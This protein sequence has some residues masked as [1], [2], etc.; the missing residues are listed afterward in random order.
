[1]IDF[2]TWADMFKSTAENAGKKAGEV[3]EVTKIKMQIAQ[4]RTELSRAY[5]K[6]GAMVYDMMKNDVQD[7]S[8]VDVCIDE[9]D[10]ILS[11]ITD[12]ESKA[13]ELKKVTVCA[14]CG[15]EMALD[16][17]FCSKCGAKAAGPEPVAEE[18]VCEECCC[19][20]GEKAAEPCCECAE[21]T[22][23]PCCE[24]SEQTEA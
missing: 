1:M 4:Q 5:E 24:A 11:R 8:A 21:E 13:N 14:S 9:I 7:S 17:C 20:C 19:E 10:F 15:A 22:A 12:A 6:L 18:A 16:A 23:E 3:L 2:T